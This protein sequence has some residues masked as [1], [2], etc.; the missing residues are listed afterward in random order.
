MIDTPHIPGSFSFGKPYGDWDGGCTDIDGQRW[1]HYPGLGWKRIGDPIPP[2]SPR[3][4]SN[5]WM[6]LPLSRGC[7][8]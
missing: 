3:R 4:W 7:P 5:A 2:T 1:R 6:S 8:R